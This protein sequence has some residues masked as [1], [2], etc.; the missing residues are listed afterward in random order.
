M[1]KRAN[2]VNISVDEA[3]AKISRGE[4]LSDFDAV[5]RLTEEDIREQAAQDPEERNWDWAR[6]SLELP[7]PK[8]GIHIKLDADIIAFFKRGGGGY[9]TRINAALK[10]FVKHAGTKRT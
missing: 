1:T 4:S 6:A 8:V 10:S 7:K 9:Q 3:K 5:S 2:I